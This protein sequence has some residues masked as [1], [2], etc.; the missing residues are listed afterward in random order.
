MDIASWQGGHSLIFP[1]RVQTEYTQSHCHSRFR[2]ADVQG[3]LACE[4]EGR[5]KA[6]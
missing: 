1:P 4:Y 5:L 6:E 2:R 3:Y